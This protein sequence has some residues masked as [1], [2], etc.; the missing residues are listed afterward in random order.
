MPQERAG[1]DLTSLTRALAEAQGV[2]ATMSFFGPDAVYDMSAFGLPRFAGRAEIR[3]FVSD[4]YA[5]YEQA[6][7]EVQ[8]IVELGNGVVFA[9]VRETARPAGSPEDAVVRARYGLIVKWSDGHVAQVTV[10]PDVD[11]ARVAAGR[12]AE[13]R[14]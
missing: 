5:S 6:D 11:A 4:W 1:P 14:A 3:A 10:D 8:E 7:D 12:L 2:E 9:V 13:G